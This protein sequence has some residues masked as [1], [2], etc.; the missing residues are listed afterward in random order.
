MFGHVERGIHH[1]PFSWE[2][3]PRLTDT[4]ADDF[5]MVSQRAAEII[6]CWKNGLESEILV[7]G[8]DDDMSEITI[9]PVEDVMEQET[10][11]F[12]QA[13]LAVGLLRKAVMELWNELD[14]HGHLIK[15]HLPPSIKVMTPQRAPLQS[16]SLLANYGK[17]SRNASRTTQ[18][19]YLALLGL[20]LKGT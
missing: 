10:N 7:I 2:R 6:K 17:K 18:F 8:N 3:E 5:P 1:A 15:D 13:R 19:K 11:G 20:K 12:K 9:V 4:P 16:F 14:S